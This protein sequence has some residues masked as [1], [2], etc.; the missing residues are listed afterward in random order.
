MSLRDL[1]ARLQPA[2][3]DFAIR[4]FDWAIRDT[5]HQSSLL[6][7]RLA[8]VKGSQAMAFREYAAT[9]S[10]EERNKL[11]VALVKGSHQL[12]AHTLKL[13]GETL[14][15]TERDWV[16][17]CHTFVLQRSSSA[18]LTQSHSKIN[19]RLLRQCVT[20]SLD[21]QLGGKHE[22]W[23][24]QELRYTSRVSGWF[25]R[26]YVD[27]GGRYK[28]RYNHAI[29]AAANIPLRE[30]IDIQSW[31]GLGHTSWDLLEDSE[32]TLAADS[33]TKLCCF[34][35]SELPAL[36]DGLSPA[37]YLGPDFENKKGS[38]RGSRR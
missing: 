29:E 27:F 8:C 36:L 19:K 12:Q 1:N 17:K 26:T 34:F 20:Q 10:V 23:G 37:V 16:E 31:M 6:F 35:L 33:L 25:V 11:A 9:M 32:M 28:L 30:W 5:I 13:K 2:R 14:D 24:P 7:P 4:L 3:N 18:I 21:N 15:P 38:V 22:R